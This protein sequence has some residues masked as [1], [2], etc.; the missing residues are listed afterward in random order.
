MPRGSQNGAAKIPTYLHHRASGRAFTYLYGSDGQRRRVYLGPWGSPG[1]KRRFREIVGGYLPDESSPRDATSDSPIRVEELVAR[2]LH[3]KEGRVVDSE[4]QRLRYSAKP[5]LDLYRDE[6]AES[7]GPKKLRR[8]RDQMVATKKL[9]RCEVNRRVVK[10]RSMFKWGVSE[11]LLPASILEALRTLAPLR[12]GQT[13][14]R[15]A[16]PVSLAHPRHIVKA[17]RRMTPTVAAMVR[18]QLCCGARPGEVIAMRTGDLERNGPDGTWIY[19]PRTHKN[20]WREQS[21]RIVL[22]ARA[23]KILKPYLRRDP[24]GFVFS[25]RRSESERRF[26][27]RQARQTPLTPSQRERDRRRREDPKRILADSWTPTT[28]R[29]AVQRACAAAHVPKWSPAQLRHNFE[30]AVERRFGVEAASKALGHADIGTTQHYRERRD[31]RVAVNVAQA[32]G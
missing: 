16:P 19:T 17:L 3:A 12:R 26:L 14:A 7:L 22:G 30:A 4:W 6:P 15:E 24:D 32:F 13:T 10:V 27:Q 29:Q 2:F 20:A 1:S 11:E 28:Y 21:R 5:L 31:L 25:P 18:L 9:S 8:V 23:Q